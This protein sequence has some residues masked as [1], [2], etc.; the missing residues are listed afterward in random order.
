VVVDAKA[1]FLF[2]GITAPREPGDV[3]M[4][5]T[6]AGLGWVEHDPYGDYEGYDVVS[7]IAI[8]MAPRGL[9]MTFVYCDGYPITSIH[10]NDV[11]YC[12][13]Q[14]PLAFHLLPRHTAVQEDYLR[15]AALKLKWGIPA[16]YL[17]TEP[18]DS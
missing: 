6:A 4:E 16:W 15:W 17:G 12:D 9:T 18:V 11:I 2:Y 10:T 14:Y 8:R 7:D 3:G 1:A 5:D 13:E